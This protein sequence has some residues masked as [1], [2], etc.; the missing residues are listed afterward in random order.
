MSFLPLNQEI[1]V[2][3]E[4][5]PVVD[6]FGDTRPGKANWQK[7]KVANWWIDRVEEKDG[8][9][10]LRT[11]SYLHV[12]VPHDVAPQPS[13]TI[14]TTDGQTWEVEGRAENYDHGFHG[15][16]PGLAVIHAKGVKG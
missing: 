2:L 13:E 15:F 5:E 1:E 8:D 10:V 14:R 9:S 4:G 3:R 6:P 11:I 12:H 7:V 16:T